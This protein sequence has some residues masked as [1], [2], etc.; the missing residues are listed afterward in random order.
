MQVIDQ[1]GRSV[2]VNTPVKRIVS[3]VPSQTE[4]LFHLGLESEVI[5]ITKFC[6]HPESWWR[7]KKRIGGTKDVN[8]QKVTVLQPDLIIGNKEENDQKNIEALAG[9]APVWM[10]DIKTL[11]EAYEMMIQI[12]QLVGKEQR[13]I[14]I[15]A[16]I[17]KQFNL[18]KPIQERKKV[19]Y[20]IWKNP[21]MMAGQNTFISEMLTECGFEN[22]TSEDRYPIFDMK[23]PIECDCVFLS[24]EP[25]PFKEK[26]VLELQIFY[27]NAKILLV[28]GEMFSW[29]GSR[30]QKAPI[31][32]RELLT[33]VG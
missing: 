22:Q 19:L 2:V 4:F 21:W 28:D 7:N 6:V 31:Y 8:L 25:Y 13:A 3:L 32:F 15:V 12:G 9:I 14:E 5:G 16:E 27:P 23:N 10:S 24:S 20:F 33:L 18:L 11:D 1:M 29:Y 26:D 17:R 30:L